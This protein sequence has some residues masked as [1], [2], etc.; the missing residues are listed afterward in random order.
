M[1]ELTKRNGK[2]MWLREVEKVL[3]RFGASLEWLTER[4]GQRDG[5]M[6]SIRQ[7]GEMEERE[8]NILLRANKAR[9][10]EEVLEEVDVL[11][12][13]HFFNE[14]SGTKSSAFLKRITTNK[15]TFE[16]NLLKKTW[17][18]SNCFPRT[19]K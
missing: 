10:I 9:S 16:M 13:V 3:K 5:E 14:F 11:I 6:D 1:E 4:M 17:R 2:G 18:S 8:K 15:N 7:N 12:D 19:M